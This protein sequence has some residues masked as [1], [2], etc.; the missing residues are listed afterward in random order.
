M[1]RTRGGSL[2]GRYRETP[3]AHKLGAMADA[4]RRIPRRP[5]RD[6]YTGGELRGLTFELVEP[7]AEPV[8]QQLHLDLM[9]AGVDGVSANGGLTTHD[10][11]EARINRVLI[12]CAREVVV[13]T[14][15]TKLGRKTFAR[16]APTTTAT[17]IIMDSEAPLR[18]LNDPR[19][20]GLR[21]VTV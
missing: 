14:D 6:R 20:M 8:P 3:F 7:L 9:F 4:K 11:V 16:I 10:P 13:V 5:P 2:P 19:R 12:D 18:L 15:H 21:V 17:T 1:V